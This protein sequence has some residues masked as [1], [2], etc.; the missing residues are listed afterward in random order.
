MSFR[1]V[2]YHKKYDP[3]TDEKER[4]TYTKV[5]KTEKELSDLGPDWGDHP[6]E[7]KS[8]KAEEKSEVTEETPSKGKSRSK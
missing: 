2:V 8:S 3:T 6:S 1:K 4:E 5:V 7:K